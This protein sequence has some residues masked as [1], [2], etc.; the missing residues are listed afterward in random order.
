MSVMP[1]SRVLAGS[2]VGSQSANCSWPGA[3]TNGTGPPC[4]AACHIASRCGASSGE[5]LML[6][7]VWSAADRSA[8]LTCS[9][10]QRSACGSVLV[11]PP[12]CAF[13][14]PLRRA[15]ACCVLLHTTYGPEAA[16]HSARPGNG[17]GGSSNRDCCPARNHLRTWRSLQRRVGTTSFRHERFGR[18]SFISSGYL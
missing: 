15:A 4:A 17:A 5:G 3:S 18:L 11:V 14:R 9:A 16:L 2:V 13:R 10:V 6:R 8:I 7:A 1:L 12:G